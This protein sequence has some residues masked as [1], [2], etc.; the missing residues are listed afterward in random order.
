LLLRHADRAGD[1][2]LVHDGRPD[3]LADLAR[4]AEA[5]S[6]PR[7]SR[8]ASSREIGSTSGVTERNTSMTPAEAPAVGVEVGRDDDRLRAH[9]AGPHHRHGAVDAGLRAS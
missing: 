2:L 3:P 6:R 1:A 8:K 9:A 7:T 4:T 5:P